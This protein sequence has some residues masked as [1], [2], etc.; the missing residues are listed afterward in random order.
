MAQIAEF[1]IIK[2]C[3]PSY[4]LLSPLCIPPNIQIVV[5]VNIETRI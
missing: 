5:T 2:F 3:K 4:Y 1:P